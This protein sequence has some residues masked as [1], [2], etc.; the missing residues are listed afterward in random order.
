MCAITASRSVCESSCSATAHRPTRPGFQTPVQ[1]AMR[2]T[3]ARE[4]KKILLVFGQPSFSSCTLMEPMVHEL[5]KT[6]PHVVV[7]RLDVRKS[8][9]VKQKY[10]VNGTPTFVVL[11]DGKM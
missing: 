9:E 1:A 2:S 4:G 8:Q 6:Y 5:E 11:Q 7:V 10:G 3:R